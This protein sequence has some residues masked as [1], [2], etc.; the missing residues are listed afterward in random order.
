MVAFGAITDTGNIPI[1]IHPMDINNI[2]PYLEI[3]HNHRN[4]G[5]GGGG[6][7]AGASSFQK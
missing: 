4:G 5:M 3:N 7:G 1:Y 6:G 2:E